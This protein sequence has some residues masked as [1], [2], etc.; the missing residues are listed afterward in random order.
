MD[1]NWT[2]IVIII[3]N[4]FHDLATAL[5]LTSAVILWVLGRRAERG[6]APERKALAEAYPTLRKFAWGAFI[7]II[8]GGIPRT[9]FFTRYEWD[10]ATVHGIIP[11]L[12]VKHAFMV[13]AIVVG[14][15]MWRRMS[16]LAKAE[17]AGE[18]RPPAG[19]ERSA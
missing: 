13:T 5:L 8:L 4:Y 18:G 15:L 14:A 6:G 9:I 19:Q 7:W 16:K 11:A 2:S 12:M 17:T 3:N 10:P 1:I